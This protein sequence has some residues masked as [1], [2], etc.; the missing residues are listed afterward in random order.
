MEEAS[1]RR[2]AESTYLGKLTYKKLAPGESKE[3]L[4][5][6]Q[7]TFNLL[8]WQDEA[9]IALAL[10][11]DSLARF[12]LDLVPAQVTSEEFWKRYFWRCD[13]LRILRNLRQQQQ[14]PSKTGA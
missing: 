5:A 2:N 7:Q 12:Y 10:Y 14:P 9:Q 3:E 8:E 1:K 4:F 6:F 11:P 13:E